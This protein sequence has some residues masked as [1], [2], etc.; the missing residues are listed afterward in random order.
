VNYYRIFS[1]EKLLLNCLGR[2][3]KDGDGILST[4]G[5]G[6]VVI[7]VLKCEEGP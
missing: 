2:F 7:N 3:L 6:L 4:Q 1:Q 5:V